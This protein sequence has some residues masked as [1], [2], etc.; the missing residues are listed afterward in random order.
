MLLWRKVNQSKI[1]F[2]KDL[3][4]LKILLITSL[5]FVLN[6]YAD[7]I[8][9]AI[10]EYKN[11]NYYKALMLFA[12]ACDSGNF[13]GCSNLGVMYSHGQG[14]LKDKMI[15]AELYAK[16]C[17]GGYSKGC[18]HLGYMYANGEGVEQDQKKAIALYTIACDGLDPIGCRD[19]GAFYFNGQGVRQNKY[20]AKEYYGKACD[21]GDQD[22]CDE[23]RKLNE[24]GY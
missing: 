4:M 22:G 8:D 5:L 13:Q 10:K 17:K 24:A 20:T 9:D 21:L 6:L 3:G 2:L 15:A 12:K 1:I 23:Y 7:D 16:A 11:S 14:V 18:S 19:L